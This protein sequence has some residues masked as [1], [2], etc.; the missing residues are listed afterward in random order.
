VDQ[1]HFKNCSKLNKPN[2]PVTSTPP[3]N[4]TQSLD[5]HRKKKENS[6]NEKDEAIP[7]QADFNSILNN[8]VI[9]PSASPSPKHKP[10][11]S[12]FRHRDTSDWILNRKIATGL[13]NEWGTRPPNFDLFTKSKKNKPIFITANH[14]K[15]IP[16]THPHSC[17]GQD[18]LSQVW[19]FQ[20]VVYANPP[21][22]LLKSAIARDG[23]R[24]QKSRI[25]A[26][27]Q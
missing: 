20:E 19:N 18:A 17:L 22:K 1:A 8:I 21:W 12:N 9:P 25:P 14:R 24:I 27:Y 7:R 13:F 5:D 2:N 4:E 11:T 26:E 23:N 16:M 15:S 10:L 3:T 6:Y